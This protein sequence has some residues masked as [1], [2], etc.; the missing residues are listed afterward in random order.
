MLTLGFSGGFPLSELNLLVAQLEHADGPLVEIRNDKG[1]TVM[2]FDEQAP[3]P[4]VL[5]VMQ[6][7]TLPAPA[8]ATL[9]CS[10]AIMI[11]GTLTEVK[12]YRAG[13]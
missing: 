8:G 6:P 2:L 7:A 1:M 13:A 11:A 10:G 5:A 3:K 9:V 12:A 4:S